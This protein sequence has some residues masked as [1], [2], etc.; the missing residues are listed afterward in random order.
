MK[1]QIDMTAKD[2]WSTL[3]LKTSQL[4]KLWLYKRL[5]GYA[6]LNALIG[7][8]IKKEDLLSY[9]I[10]L[11]PEQAF[12]LENLG[13]TPRQIENSNTIDL[14]ANKWIVKDNE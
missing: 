12:E 10:D 5:C 2:G 9:L 8:I 4:R 14:P 1:K 3:R 7:D 13:L 11:H 6:S